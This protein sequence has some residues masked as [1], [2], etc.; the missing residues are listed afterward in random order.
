MTLPS[1][2]AALPRPN[3][4]GYQASIDDPRLARAREAGP[5][6]YRRRWSSV[7]RQVALVIDL[8]RTKKAVFDQF[9]EITTGFGSMPFWMPDPVTDGWPMLSAGGLPVLTGDGAPLL[10]SGQWLCLFGAT[11]PV[12]TIL[13]LEFR[14]AFSV[15]VM[16]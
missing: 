12:E 7:A 6:G 4:Q 13:A 2:P 1:W 5:P 16:P 15:S 10:M 14:I 8:S 3:R 9:Y 11:P